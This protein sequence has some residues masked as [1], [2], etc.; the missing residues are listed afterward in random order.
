MVK[1]WG[2]VSGCHRNFPTKIYLIWHD[3]SRGKII[4]LVKKVNMYNKLWIPEESWQKSRYGGVPFLVT[5]RFVTASVSKLCGMFV[6]TCAG[7]HACGLISLNKACENKFKHDCQK[8]LFLL[9][10]TE[11]YFWKIHYSKRM[12]STASESI[13][14]YTVETV[15]LT[16]WFVICTTLIELATRKKKFL[17]ILWWSTV[18]KQIFITCVLWKNLRY[19]CTK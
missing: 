5:G 18:R 19:T 9:L 2:C 6:C 8:F 14:L 11:N 15:Y 4:L 17:F 7:S 10:R 1:L 16:S 13:L 12:L 3:F